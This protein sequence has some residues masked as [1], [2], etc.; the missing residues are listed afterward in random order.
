MAEHRH[1]GKIRI[2]LS[3]D[4]GHTGEVCRS[5][6]VLKYGPLVLAPQTYARNPLEMSTAGAVPEGWGG[7]VKMELVF[8][9]LC[10]ATS[11]LGFYP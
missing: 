2:E 6:R 10:S 9:P 5:E 4:L 1:A 8:D 11:Y 3:G 7:P